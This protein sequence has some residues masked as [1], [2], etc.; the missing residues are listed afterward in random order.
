MTLM[1]HNIY[2]FTFNNLNWIPLT[3]LLIIAAGLS[4]PWSARLIQL[5]QYTYIMF[6]ELPSHRKERN[7]GSG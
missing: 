7:E 1:E 6:A 5:K 2:F 4:T 3:N